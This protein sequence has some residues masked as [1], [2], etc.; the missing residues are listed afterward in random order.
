MTLKDFGAVRVSDELGHVPLLIAD[1]SEPLGALRDRFAFCLS[2]Q[3]G[4]FLFENA[5]K[6]LLRRIRSVDLLGRFQQIE[7]QL[8]AISLEKI[9]A[10]ACQSIDHL[11]STHF[12]RAPPGVQIAVA[13]KSDAMLLDAHVAHAHFVDELIDG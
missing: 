2:F 4:S 12:L 5:I 7:S 13:V 11:R 10:P 9:M 1:V 8:M 3:C 6:K